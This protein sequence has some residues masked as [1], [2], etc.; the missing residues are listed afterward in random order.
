MKTGLGHGRG[1]L[2][3]LSVFT[4]VSALAA[5]LPP[6]DTG[7]TRMGLGFSSFSGDVLSLQCARG[8]SVV[9]HHGTSDIRYAQD[10]FPEELLHMQ[11]S[12]FDGL[13]RYPAPES[14]ALEFAFANGASPLAWTHVFH[15]SVARNSLVLSESSVTDEALRIAQTSPKELARHCGDEFVR[16]VD[17][18][19]ALIVVL[20][21]EF[22]SMADRRAVK[23]NFSMQNSN[24]QPAHHLARAIPLEV[25]ER[26][27]IK[28]SARK[29]GGNRGAL[30][31]ILPGGQMMCSLQAPDACFEKYSALSA[32]ART[33][34]D[35]LSQDNAWAEIGYVTA[36]YAESG[37]SF[38][39]F[40]ADGPAVLPSMK[41][42]ERKE[43]LFSELG[44]ESAAAER[45][46]LLLEVR[47][48]A[49][50][51]RERQRFSDVRE[52]AGR[53]MRLLQNALR[54]CR[55]PD[56]ARCLAVLPALETYD[57]DLA[58]R[59]L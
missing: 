26:T 14:K 49:I 43:Q 21:F 50:S 53:N 18:G 40:Q 27:L 28:V 37:P 36:R 7:R 11:F 13:L 9:L 16:Q 2:A 17:Y 56:E 1:I 24:T 15:A 6:D 57:R 46:R 45:A 20:R 47:P 22:A 58:I 8:E 54:E 4:S 59:E 55:T 41:I 31:Q 44:R 19:A 33:L 52:K 29:I 23:A 39:V 48:A 3:L 25:R 32:H 10:V 30:D 51:E 34:S 5:N 35:E 12:D 42:F 38:E